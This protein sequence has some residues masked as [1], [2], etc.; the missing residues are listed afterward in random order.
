MFHVDA[1]ALLSGLLLITVIIAAGSAFVALRQRGT[2]IAHRLQGAAPASVPAEITPAIGAAVARGLGPLARLATPLK[3]EEF[4]HLR[5]QL[6][7]GGF[8]GEAAVPIFLG[9][10]VLLAAAATLLFLWWDSARSVP[11]D[12]TL[13]W[14]T[15]AFAVGYYAPTV[16]LRLRIRSRQSDLERA[17]PDALD[18]LVTCVEAGLALD[19]A[20]QRVSGEIRF[21]WPLLGA[22]LNQTFLET[23]AGMPHVEAF[24]RVAQRTGV[25]DLKAL[26]AT[27]TQTEMFGTRVGLALRVQA[28]GIRTRRMNRAEERAGYVAVKM[29]LPLTL[30]IL[31]T[32]LCF[33]VG[34]AIVNIA[35]N[36]LPTFGVR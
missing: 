18:L 6:V 9:L 17:L 5:L 1:V 28:E 7:R 3:E 23:K 33:V 12:W 29:A 4:S 19:A 2:L 24:R 22:E 8:R 25:A 14:A 20:I 36:L 16:W 35:R 30:C 26:A 10:K 21:A 31:P 27:L 13:L 15:A 11:L 34:P 32:L